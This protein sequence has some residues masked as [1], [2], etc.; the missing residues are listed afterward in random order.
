MYIVKAEANQVEKIVDI[1][2]TFIEICRLVG[3]LIFAILSLFGD[4]VYA[5]YKK[6][7]AIVINRNPY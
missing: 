3:M 2:D 6:I 4:M 5:A 7:V 1:F